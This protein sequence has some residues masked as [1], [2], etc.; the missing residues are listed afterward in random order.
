MD[1]YLRSYGA[2][3]KVSKGRSSSV[4]IKLKKTF[5]FLR[6]PFRLLL[7]DYNVDLSY[8]P[9]MMA[10]SFINSSHARD[11]EFQQCKGI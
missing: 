1:G 11:M 3:L 7:K 2:L 5:F 4:I 10:D 8:T 9:M 6:L